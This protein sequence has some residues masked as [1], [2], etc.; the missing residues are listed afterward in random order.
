MGTV[1]RKLQLKPKYMVVVDWIKRELQE[2][3]LRSGSKLPSIRELSMQLQCSKNTV[4][5]AYDYL[6]LEHIIY[7]KPQSGFYIVNDYVTSVAH[8]DVIDFLAAGPMKN[9][10]PYKDFQHCLNTAIDTFQEELFQYGDPQGLY[11][12][13][14]EIA[15]RLQNLQVFTNPEQLVIVS[16][17]QQALHLLTL[18]NFPNG[19]CNIVIE[20]PTYFGMVDV[21]EISGVQ[22]FGV[23]LKMD[24]IDLHKLEQLFKEQQIKF[25]YVIP[26]F[27]NPLGHEYTNEEKKK[28]I[29]LANKYDVYIVED[30]FLGEL[31]QNTKADPFFS[32]DTE[33]RVIYIQ[34]YSKTFL[35]GLRIASMILPK[36]FIVPFL[37]YKQSADFTS[38]ILSQGALAIYLKSGMY[39]RHLQRVKN[40]YAEKM[41]VLTKT[42]AAYLPP[43]VTYT[44]PTN[45][46]YL[47]LYCPQHISAKKIAKLLEIE[48]VIVDAA[49][50][51][52]LPDYKNDALIRLCISQVTERQIK[53]GV[54]KIAH[55]FNKLLVR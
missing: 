18:M 15:K 37:K 48:N 24:G 53:E 27:H 6:Q 20:Q 31:D 23:E 38:P 5:K 45:G 8:S 11:S 2:D 28:I 29:A 32:F 34:S 1:G 40:I 22:A 10:I 47:A 52:F 19:K 49:D 50:R 12:L 55:V 7:A 44:K 9:L 26:R 35:P 16:G 43:E 46:Y 54:Q 36:A 3:R 30:D 25:F 33:N 51:M 4:L 17:S 41:M 39:A 21:I 42:C 14:M 13:R